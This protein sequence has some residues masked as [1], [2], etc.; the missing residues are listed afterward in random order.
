MI[1]NLKNSLSLVVISRYV[2]SFKSVN[3]VYTKPKRRKCQKLKNIFGGQESVGRSIAMSPILTFFIVS[4]QRAALAHF[5][6]ASKFFGDS[7]I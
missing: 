7:E 4:N 6:F 1:N 3:F 2:P 5:L